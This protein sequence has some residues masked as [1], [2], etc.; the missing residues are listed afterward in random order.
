MPL[1]LL[2]SL[3]A[4]LLLGGAGAWYVLNQRSLENQ[5]K[6]VPPPSGTM[7]PALTKAGKNN[8]NVV[9]PIAAQAAIAQPANQP[10]VE[11]PLTLAEE[12][13]PVLAI[14]VNDAQ[15]RERNLRPPYCQR[16]TAQTA[17]DCGDLGT[18]KT[19]LDLLAHGKRELAFYRV[20]PLTSVAWQQLK[21]ADKPG[22][23]KTL[24]DA[25]AAAADLPTVGRFS[26]DSAAWL[27]AA[28][29][30]GRARP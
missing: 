23:G 27:A 22:A 13:D 16:V 20:G 25:L 24:D 19:F 9:A 1:I 6:S 2:V 14:M 21:G 29:V 17:A 28:L 10:V 30:A 4:L 26:I 11:K 3:G 8:P 12:R 7:P 5:Q 15:E 18:A